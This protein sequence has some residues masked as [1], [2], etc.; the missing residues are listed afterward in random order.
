MPIELSRQTQDL[1]EE[2]I[3]RY[4]F[5]SPDEAIEQAFE[6]FEAHRPT[7][8]SL[9]ELLREAHRSVEAGD[10]ATLDADSTGNVGSS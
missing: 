4:G 9:N 8:D 5:A 6:V 1:V 10:I 2:Q 7:M 3:R